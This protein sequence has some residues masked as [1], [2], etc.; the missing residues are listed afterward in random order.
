MEEKW[1]RRAFAGRWVGADG[2]LA[3]VAGC[4]HAERS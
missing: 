4:A 1:E 2:C 3:V